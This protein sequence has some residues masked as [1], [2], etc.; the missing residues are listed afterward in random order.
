MCFASKPDFKRKNL[1]AKCPSG[2]FECSNGAC[3]REAKHCDRKK[4]CPDG[5][6][7]LHCDDINCEAPLYWKCEDG[8]CIQTK[9]KCDGNND[10][11][12]WSD[13]KD[14]K[15]SK[16]SDVQKVC[17]DEDFACGDGTC[18]PDNWV[19]DGLKDCQ[20]GND[21]VLGCSKKLDCGRDFLCSN[22]HCVPKAWECDGNND[23][24]DNSD[25]VNC[26]PKDATEGCTLDKNLFSCHDKLK[27]VEVAEVC[28]GT[29]HCLDGSDEGPMC[30][31]SK[32][33]CPNQGCSFRCQPTPS[34]PVCVC[35][36]GFNLVNE[37]Y[38]S[39]I[40]ECKMYGI[41]SQKCRNKHGSYECFCDQG[42]TLQSDNHTCTVNEGEAVLLFSTKTEVRVYFMRNEV[43]RLVADGQQHVAG[44]AYDGLYVYW[45]SVRN[46]EEAIIRSNHD[47]SITDVLVSSEDFVKMLEGTDIIPANPKSGGR[48]G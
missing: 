30:Q 37:K 9:F 48:S 38:C 41:C 23:C 27:C 42:Y 19:C 34:G 35:P 5:A 8:R 4:D 47:G 17:S 24:G 15:A 45:T 31:K 22:H 40:D 39:D 10:C 7:E 6:D 28:D 18:I 44:V 11:G 36:M 13:E 2:F 20:N 32:A 43:Y 16:V 25:E 26:K 29:P 1:C 21:E 3:I 12:D 46:G 33:L 14:C